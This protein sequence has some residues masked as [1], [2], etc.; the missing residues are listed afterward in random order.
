MRFNDLTGQ[1]FGKL[2][3]INRADSKVD[4]SGRRRT[5]WSCVCDCG[6]VKVVSGDY[7]KQSDVPSCGCEA[8]KNKVDKEKILC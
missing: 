2:T 8:L 6:N 7:L 4:N 3:V 5:M 1:K